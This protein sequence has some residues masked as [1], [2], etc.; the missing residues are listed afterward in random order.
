MV[1]HNHFQRVKGYLQDALGK[2]ATI[3]YG[4]KTY[5]SQ[6][7]MEPTV[8]VN[9]S[10]DSELWEK[11]IFGPILPFLNFSD[12][13]EAIDKINS[14]EKPLALYIFS[15]NKDNINRIIK[16]TRAGGTC[17]NH[18]GIHFFNSNLPFGGSNNSGIGKGHGFFG[19]ESF[20]NPR[21]ILKQWAPINGLDNMTAPY[22]N[23]K[24][25]LIDMTI[26]WF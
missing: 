7:Y 21:A 3:A 14:K 16:N 19:F 9:I 20:S 6:D 17:I 5:D 10:D 11:E 24:Q 15:E 1:N 12:L 8:V 23:K 25:K 4:G 22:N 18:V 26:K 2:G 13:Q